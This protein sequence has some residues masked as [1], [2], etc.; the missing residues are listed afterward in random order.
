MCQG[1]LV[2]LCSWIHVPVS[3]LVPS[4]VSLRD[5][6]PSCSLPNCISQEKTS[7][8]LPSPITCSYLFVFLIQRLSELF[9]NLGNYYISWFSTRERVHFRGCCYFKGTELKPEDAAGVQCTICL[10]ALFMVSFME[11]ILLRRMNWM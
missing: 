11:P 5:W 2:T 6:D 1:E 10:A 4:T 9:C 3:E 7:K 8:P